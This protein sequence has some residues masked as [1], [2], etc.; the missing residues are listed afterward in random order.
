[1]MRLILRSSN[2]KDEYVLHIILVDINL[3]TK[4]Y[5]IKNA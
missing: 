5:N 4:V 1:M 3:P 2:T